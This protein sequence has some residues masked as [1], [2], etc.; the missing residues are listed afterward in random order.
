MNKQIRLFVVVLV[1]MLL[2]TVVASA[3]EVNRCNTFWDCKN[4]LHWHLGWV[5]EYFQGFPEH[6]NNVHT[7]GEAWSDVV[8]WLNARAEEALSLLGGN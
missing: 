8:I 6:L 2:L 4:E 5:Y 7:N 1:V 3:T